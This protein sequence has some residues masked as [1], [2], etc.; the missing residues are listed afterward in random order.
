MFELSLENSAGKRAELTNRKEYAV[1][2]IQGLNP[3]SAKIN[4]SETALFDGGRFNSSK[5][6]MRSINIALT[7]NYEAEKNRIALYDVVR[8]KEQINIYYKNGLRDVFIP[9][10][11]ESF[12]VNYFANKQTAAIS[13]LC[14]EPYFRAA[15]DVIN[16]VSM[17]VGA[18]HFP[19]AITAEEPIPFSYY[20]EIA[21][22]DVVNIGDVTSGLQIEIRAEGNVTNPRI[23]NRDTREFFGIQK[24]FEPG[25][26]IYIDTRKGQKKARLLRDGEYINI[27]N[28]IEKGSTWLQL[29][30]GDNIMTYEGDGT[31]AE[32]MSV[33]FIHSPLY[34]GV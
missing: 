14:P 17:I 29:T 33:R 28:S 8:V 7:L 3:P 18:F 22:I 11:V 26:V 25:D 16:E 19:F 6:N 24:E 21:E 2:E 9:G 1:T 4:T 15:Q 10:Y 12:T 34:E 30:P 32:Y 23:Y 5:V 20:G 13:I 31:S 27:F